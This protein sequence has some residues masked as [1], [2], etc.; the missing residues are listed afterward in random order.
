MVFTSPPENHRKLDSNIVLNGLSEN[1]R[2]SHS[3][4]ALM[5]LNEAVNESHC[6]HRSTKFY[7]DP[8]EQKHTVFLAQKINIFKI[9]FLK[10]PF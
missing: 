1:H 7:L 4:I 10:L 2:K 6:G 3:N 9:Y 5:G 8:S